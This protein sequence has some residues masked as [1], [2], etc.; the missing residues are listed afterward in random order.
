MYIYRAMQ[1]HTTPL[2]WA[3]QDGHLAMAQLLLARGADVNRAVSDGVTSLMWASQNGHAAV[4]ELVALDDADI[5][6]STVQN[7]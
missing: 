2:Y 6:Y 4:V 5:K 3:C 7:W 1:D